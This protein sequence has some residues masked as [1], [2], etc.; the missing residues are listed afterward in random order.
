MPVDLS[1]PLPCFF[2]HRLFPSMEPVNGLLQIT[3]E[4][5]QRPVAEV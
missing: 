1:R 2:L 4:N 5:N 3:L